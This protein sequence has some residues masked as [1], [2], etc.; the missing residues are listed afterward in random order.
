[1]PKLLVIDDEPSIHFSI[2][3]VFAHEAI[4]VIMPNPPKMDCVWRRRNLRM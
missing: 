1:M 2:G 4:Q 3:R